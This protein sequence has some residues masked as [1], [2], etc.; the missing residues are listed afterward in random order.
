MTRIEGNARVKPVLHLRTLA[1]TA[2]AA[3]TGLANIALGRIE[4]G[5]VRLGPGDAAPDFTLPGSDG[6][7][8]SLRDFRGRQPVVI[9]WFPKAFTPGCTSECRSLGASDAALRQQGVQYFAASVDS[10]ETNAEFARALQLPYPILSDE[11]REVARAYGVLT[12]SGFPSRWTFYIGADGRILDVDRQVHAPAHG[13]A[14]GAR[15]RELGI[16]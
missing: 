7:A 3:A 5:G 4:P 11:T 10:P 9:A 6:R 15:L 13:E 14:I 16:S 8:Y 12:A 2:R 1:T